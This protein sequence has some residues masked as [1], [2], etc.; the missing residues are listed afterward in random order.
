LYPRIKAKAILFMLSEM[1]RRFQGFNALT[2]YFLPGPISNFSSCDENQIIGLCQHIFMSSIQSS[3]SSFDSVSHHGIAYFLTGDDRHPGK[4]Q[5]IGKIDEDKIFSSKAGTVFVYTKKIFP[6]SYSFMW[7]K[8][9]IHQ[10]ASFFLP[11]LL[12]FL[13]ISCPPLDRMRTRNP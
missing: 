13:R 5:L 6:F 11:F 8:G 7:P 4:M 12:L 9:F 3:H 1:L 10:T 2:A